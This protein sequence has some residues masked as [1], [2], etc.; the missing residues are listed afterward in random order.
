MNE[1]YSFWDGGNAIGVVGVI[2]DFDEGSAE[3]VDVKRGGRL[4]NWQV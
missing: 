3:G 4:E 2:Q 1:V